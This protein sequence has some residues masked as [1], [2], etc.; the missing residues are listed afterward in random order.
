MFVFTYK[1][2]NF[3]Y[4]YDGSP[5]MYFLGLVDEVRD[6]SWKKVTM[7][8]PKDVPKM[9]GTK[10]FV[11]YSN[12][13]EFGG[14]DEYNQCSNSMIILD[15]RNFKRYSADHS[16]SPSP[17]FDYSVCSK[18]DAVFLYGG[19]DKT[20]IFND[21]YVF[22]NSIWQQ[23]YFHG[24]SPPPLHSSIL[25]DCGEFLMLDGGES[26]DSVHDGL[27]SLDIK[28]KKVFS[29]KVTGPSLPNVF[30]SDQYQLPRKNHKYCS[31]YDKLFVIDGFTDVKKKEP[32]LNSFILHGINDL[33]TM[34]KDESFVISHLKRMKD[35]KKFCDVVFLTMNEDKSGYNET[36][37]H[38]CIVSSRC[39]Y[40]KDLILNCDDRIY[41]RDVST[42][43]FEEY[44][45][46]L[47]T[48][49]IN[50]TTEQDISQFL[51]FSKKCKTHH[52]IINQIMNSIIY[53]DIH[54]IIIDDIKTDFYSMIND[55]TFSDM[56]FEIIDPETFEKKDLYLHLVFLEQSNYFK[57]I[58]NSG[59]K[60]SI[61]HLISFCEIKFC[62]MNQIINF[63][64]T[65]DILF[66]SSSTIEL[67]VN[68]TLFQLNEIV[69]YCRKIIISNI[70]FENSL[71]LIF[72]ADLYSDSM[73]INACIHFIV[74]HYEEYEDE[75]IRGVPS[76]AAFQILQS[77]TKR[78]KMNE[79]K[80]KK[81]LM[82]EAKSIL[83]SSNNIINKTLLK[84]VIANLKKN[85]H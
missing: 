80:E 66:E 49:C 47:Y 79:R 34:I 7:N 29:S 65:D 62:H 63:L 19:R 1:E 6:R 59:M 58:I 18:D 28:L 70:D 54:K 22:Q 69:S 12:L 24:L 32:C 72:L 44:L 38:K 8:Q 82:K 11:I 3:L 56:K 50:L 10:P 17:R 41:I 31:I 51:Y 25:F 33:T 16:L 73:L 55:K 13:Y 37:A 26:F 77:I 46:F 15:L 42:L 23:I 84:N 20:N 64:Y 81:Q 45:N 27:Y 43:V 74:N 14:I 78:Q 53:I 4:L 60:E 83:S 61:E 30:Q 2:K 48:G 40:L 39:L 5:E 36:H 75:D 67:F 71:E 68:A 52:L 21:L 9:N 57:S 85:K 35:S 76:S